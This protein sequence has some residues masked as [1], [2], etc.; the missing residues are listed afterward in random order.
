[1][2]YITK[3]GDNYLDISYDSLYLNNYLQYSFVSCSF[4]GVEML[5]QM[6][7]WAELFSDGNSYYGFYSSKYTFLFYFIFVD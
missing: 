6:V 1:M 5:F 4:Y 7:Y 2:D 3:V